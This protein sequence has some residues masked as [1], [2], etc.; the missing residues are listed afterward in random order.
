MPALTGGG[1]SSVTGANIVDGTVSRADI[2]V[3]S[4]SAYSPIALTLMPR[5]NGAWDNFS[6]LT[7]S[8]NTVMR[9]G[10]VI[11]EQEISVN[12]VSL[13][14]NGIT[15]Q[16]AFQFG[17]YTENGATRLLT[18]TTANFTANY[19]VQTVTLGAAVLVPAG[20][21]Y[22]GVVSVGTCNIDLPTFGDDV[23]TGSAQKLGV[24]SGEPVISGTLTVTASTVPASITPTAITSAIN[25]TIL[26]R[27]DN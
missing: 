19:Q 6:N 11:I 26:F 3:S 5:Y 23:A 13:I 21:Y 25:C 17:L 12:K 4:D 24:V 10:Q 15:V 8:V 16:G 1:A 27:L 2:A 18:G 14:C 20:V 22:W 9:I 7:L